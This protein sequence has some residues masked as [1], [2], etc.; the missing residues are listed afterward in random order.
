MK[1]Y[2]AIA[3]ALVSLGYRRAYTIPGT[4]IYHLNHALGDRIHQTVF[5]HEMGATFAADAYGRVTGTPGLAIVTAGPGILNG[6]SGLGQAYAE[7]SPLLYIT[8]EVARG[9]R[10]GFHGVDDPLAVTYSSIPVAKRVYLVEDPGSIWSVMGEAHYTALTGRRG[11]VHVSIPYDVLQSEVG[12]GRLEQRE[13]DGIAR[14]VDVI[15]EGLRDGVRGVLVIGMELYPELADRLLDLFE[16]WP[17]IATV[18]QIG[19]ARLRR[20]RY[21]GHIEKKFQIHPVAKEILREAEY[22][23]A[24]GI[25][26][27]SP[28]AEH[29]SMLSK[30]ARI[31]FL[32]PSEAGCSVER[33]GKGYHVEAPLSEAIDLLS[34]GE[35]GLDHDVEKMMRERLEWARETVYSEKGPRIHQGVAA[36]MISQLEIDGYTVTC[37]TGGNEQWIREFIPPTRDVRYLYSGG[38]GS[39]GYSLPA[40]IGAYD[41]EREVLAVTGDG[42]LMMSLGELKTIVEHGYRVKIAVFNDS[43][44]GILEMLSRSDIGEE[45]EGGI[46]SVD[47]AKVAEALGMESMAVETYEDLEE[48]LEELMDSTG[49]FLLDIRCS[50]E[51]VPT[52]LR[53][54]D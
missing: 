36:H 46:G 40:S 31:D 24:V 5:R 38:F 41:A 10:Y 23:L 54:S 39:I 33:I 15:N 51:E 14:C 52:L 50:P 29:I 32:R 1:V 8:G 26:P 25:P 42:S 53:K 28:E 4:H 34:P 49:P 45:I 20:D 22:I 47:F 6:L 16:T 44:Y 7:A 35:S 11:P 43:T 2:E 13:T 37:D 27:D 21:A 9:E 3:D 30:D 12:E 19:M 48:G 18:G 17:Y